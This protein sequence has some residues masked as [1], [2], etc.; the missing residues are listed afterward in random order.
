MPFTALHPDAGR[1]DATQFDLGC[2]MDWARVH[3][4]RPR[5]PLACPECGWPLH[6]KHSPQGVRFFCHDPG[7]PDSCELA[8]ESFQHHLLKLELAAAIRDAG[9]YAGLEV[10]ARDGSWR[11]DVMASSPDGRQR[12]AWEAQLSPVTDQDILARTA[13]YEAEGIGACWVCPHPTP[14]KWIDVVPAVLIRA[15][16]E[17]GQ[18]W[19]VTDG[20]GTFDAAAGRW[21]FR[22][23]EL[24]RFVR[25][26][27]LGQVEPARSLPHY[28]WASRSDDADGLVWR[29]RRLWWTPAQSI[30]D[31]SEHDR[32]RREKEEQAR[33]ATAAS[34]RQK[35][36]QVRRPQR[37]RRPVVGDEEDRALREEQ[38]RQ[39]RK[40]EE[41]WAREA[42]AR[43]EKADRAEETARA[44]WSRVSG[45]QRA[46]LLAAV[47][48]RAW[49]EEETQVEIPDQPRVSA[50]FAYGIPLH[51]RGR[52][53]S[54]YGIVRPCPELVCLSPQL[55]FQQILVRNARE[56]SQL[57]EV[58]SGRARIAHFGLQ[59]AE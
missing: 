26:V 23:E 37:L 46:Q 35:E 38:R 57:G 9:W 36:P 34:G 49:R 55:E 40:R 54:L 1:L 24:G 53:R 5:V 13:R 19:R 47:A 17:L 41:Q 16:K 33:R 56:A 42:A 2:G 4:A 14:P 21:K 39:E 51:T 8:H 22:Q 11:A 20:L 50:S 18:P 27:L 48:D 30:R 7:R 12:V 15:P 59:D 25:W 43:A 31:Q 6:A 28:E 32:K 29:R 3:K 44:W 52:L 45:P 10:A 58:M